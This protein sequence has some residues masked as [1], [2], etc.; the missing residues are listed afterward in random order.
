MGLTVAAPSTEP[1]TLAETK[2]HL[3]VTHTD[4]DTRIGNL[5]VAAREYWEKVLDRA[6]VNETCVLKLNQ[7]PADTI[8]LPRSPLSSV[9]SIAYVDANGDSQTWD[10]ANY[11]KHTDRQPGE[12]SRA[13]NV[14]WPTIR[15]QEDAVT[16]TYVAGYGANETSVPEEAR[17]LLLLTVADSYDIR[18]GHSDFAMHRN[19]AIDRLAFGLRVGNI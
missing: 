1:I 7:F 8:R 18:G 9:T 15:D 17:H 4:H 19:E 5:I 12:I 6:F 2:E 11:V 13:Y 16:I 14:G 10:A 3:A